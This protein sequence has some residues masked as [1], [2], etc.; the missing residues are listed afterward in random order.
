MDYQT[1]IFHEQF[2]TYTFTIDIDTF[3]KVF[4]D[5]QYTAGDIMY[6]MS[7]VPELI[8]WTNKIDNKT[9]ISYTVEIN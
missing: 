6:I 2:E 7:D 8:K 4:E 3:F 1:I 5:D 9:V